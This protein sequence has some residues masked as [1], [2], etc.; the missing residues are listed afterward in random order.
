MLERGSTVELA[1]GGHVTPLA[2]DTLRDRR[3]V[4]IEEGRASAE[5]LSLVPK[6]D[7]RSLA[8]GS[9][10]TGVLL[11]RALVGFLRGRGLVVQDLGAEGPDPV[12]YPDVAAQVAHCVARGEADAGVIIDG[13]GIGSAIAANKIPGIR[14]ATACSETTARYGREHH[15][16][17]VLTI[18]AT[19]V[20]V[21]EAESIVS[22]W[23]STSMSD[24][25]DIRRL[26]KIRDLERSGA[27]RQ[28]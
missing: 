25:N 20:S 16:T 13:A 2:R 27:G 17:N 3:I 8:I 5:D 23:L 24:P 11:K 15:G 22:V 1:R 18:G 26:A 28:E 4:V 14:A 9:D 7:I 12:D 10:H 19:L 6:A 21:K